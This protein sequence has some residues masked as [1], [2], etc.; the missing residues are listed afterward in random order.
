VSLDSWNGYEAILNPDKEP[1]EY[2]HVVFQDKPEYLEDHQ[3]AVK[4]A[5]LQFD[6]LY[7]DV[8]TLLEPETEVEEFE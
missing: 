8:E 7:G 5:Q 3:A 4:D 1:D 6:L 2:V